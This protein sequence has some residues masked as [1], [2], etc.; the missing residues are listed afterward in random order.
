MQV[1][2]TLASLRA[3]VRRP[4]LWAVV[5]GGG[6][7]WALVRLA[8][9]GPFGRLG[10][11]EAL[12]PIPMLAGVLV[13]G[14]LPWQLGGG[15]GRM[16]PPFRGLLQALPWNVVWVMLLLMAMQA[17]HPPPPAPPGTSPRGPHPTHFSLVLLSLFVPL[18][19]AGGG[20][21]AHAQ[22]SEEKAEAERRLAEETRQLALQ[23]QMQPHALYNAMSGLAE[24]AREDGEA[25]EAALISL[26]RYL[27]RLQKHCQART[28]PLAE[29]RA[30]LEAYLAI[31]K[32]RLGERLQVEWQWPGWA[33]A[34]DLP[35]LLLQPL[36]E[37]AVE[38]GL[39]A[40]AVGGRLRIFVAREPGAVILGVA[41]DG[42]PPKGDAPDGQ[43]M[44]HL[45]ERLA[46]WS[47][48][49]AS[50]ELRQEDLETLARIRIPED[51]A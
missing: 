43:G 1:S 50:L 34:L 38:H 44:G 11:L 19:T 3:R 40:K 6:A 5:L 41:N 2:E 15:K 20:L 26:S 4:G 9:G 45:R 22:A 17:L 51:L 33:D 29:E 31:A 13:L 16:P 47:S 39:A 23:A 48:N 42:L 37:N 32:I 12:L 36:V 18:V 30:L 46:L 35:P 27:R 28:Q 10:H 25:T 14:P 49:R 8:M 7:L 21:M 24:L